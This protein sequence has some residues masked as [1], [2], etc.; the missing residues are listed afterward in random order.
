MAIL[1]EELT[2]PGHFTAVGQRLFPNSSFKFSR[3]F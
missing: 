1:P 2:F 3:Y